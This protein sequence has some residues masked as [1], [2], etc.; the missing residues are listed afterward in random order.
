MRILN[1]WMVQHV[2]ILRPFDCAA[3]L[4]TCA[5]LNHSTENTKMLCEHFK[6]VLSPKTSSGHVEWINIVHSL[7][8]HNS[9]TNEL[10]ASVLSPEVITSIGKQSTKV[11]FA[12]F[13]STRIYDSTVYNFRKYGIEK[14]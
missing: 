14:Q 4:L 2:K 9:H 13:F 5:V 8:V 1:E 12:K 11:I 10:L 6:A 7:L 3:W